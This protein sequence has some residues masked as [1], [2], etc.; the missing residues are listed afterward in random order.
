MKGYIHS[1]ETLGALD[2]PG[3]RVVVF[4]Q[5]CPMRC[6]YCQNPDTWLM[7]D[8]ILTDTKTLIK[9]IE[10]YK[11]YFGLLGG[12]TVSGGEPFMQTKFLM[13]LLKSLEKRK[14]KTVIDTC[15]YYLSLTVKNCLKYTDLVLLDIK[16]TVDAKHKKLT[17]KPL[18]NMLKFFNYCCS[19]R[20]K[21]WIRQV[22]IPGINDTKKDMQQLASF[23]KNC[24]TV[25][26]VELLPY[27]S[28]GKWKWKKL[29]KK[30][31]FRGKKEPTPEKIRELQAF[32]SGELKYLN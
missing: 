10:N 8:G 20:K 25:Q 30:Y 29:G 4:F 2:G 5:G 3:L 21:I 11:P 16:H 32:L 14:I 22:I 1:I 13:S 28:M 7:K 6:K 12:V 31:S 9:K 15:G 27:H 24:K 17:G 18:S 26:K 23:V 19:Q